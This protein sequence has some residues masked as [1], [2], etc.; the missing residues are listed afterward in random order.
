MPRYAARASRHDI[1]GENPDNAPTIFGIRLRSLFIPD[2]MNPT[3][4]TSTTSPCEGNVRNTGGGSILP[5]PVFLLQPKTFADTSF[6]KCGVGFADNLREA[7]NGKPFIQSGF[8]LTSGIR[9]LR[10]R[11]SPAIFPFAL[12]SSGLLSIFLFFLATFVAR[13]KQI[14]NF[15]F[16][17]ACGGFVPFPFGPR[18]SAAA[19]VPNQNRNEH[20]KPLK[21]DNPQ[22]FRVVFYLRNGTR[23]AQTPVAWLFLRTPAPLLS[24]VLLGAS[25]WSVRLRHA[26]GANAPPL[27]A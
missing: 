25:W 20:P 5:P 12:R 14:T 2:G 1:A 10:C 3:H 11:L 13:K 22:R 27:G 17:S 23:T 26:L 15:A 18:N 21:R 6:T 7:Q 16:G 19:A 8:P 4:P 9:A 24:L